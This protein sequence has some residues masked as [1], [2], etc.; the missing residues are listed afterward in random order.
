MRLWSPPSVKS[1]GLSTTPDI[2]FRLPSCVRACVIWSC[3]ML[4]SIGVMGISPQSTTLAQ[5]WY[6]FT[7]ARALNPRSECWRPDAWRIA[8]GPKRA[9]GRYVTAVSKGAPTTAMSYGSVG[10]VRH[11]TWRRWAKVPIPPNAHCGIQHC[12]K[13]DRM[14]GAC[15]LGSDWTNLETPFCLELGKFLLCPFFVFVVMVAG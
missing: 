2:V 1:L 14:V 10:S 13:A 8:R 5:L 4:L 15:G 9:P 11:L 12:S 3:A 7:P 6:G